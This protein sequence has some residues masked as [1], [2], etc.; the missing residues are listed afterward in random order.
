M[1]RA[2]FGD[3]FCFL[4]LFWFSLQAAFSPHIMNISAL[5][6]LAWKG[7]RMSGNLI[8]TAEMY[9]KTVY[10]LEEDGI[11]ALRARIVDRLG[12][13]GPTVSE[14]VAR[15]ERD[16]L[17]HVGAGRKIY[18]TDK[19]FD[20]AEGVMRRHRLAECLLH[21]VIGLDWASVHD[22]A[23]RWEHVVSD[24]V[25]DRIEVLLNFPERDP[26]GNPI[27]AKRDPEGCATALNVRDVA[28]AGLR[29]LGDIARSYPDTNGEN[30]FEIA[31]FS[32]R[33]QC[34][35]SDLQ[36]FE[37]AGLLI[38]ANVNVI[39]CGDQE[40]CVSVAGAELYIPLVVA[41]GIY[42]R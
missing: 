10:E 15:L 30:T 39:D 22:E 4:A 14:T 36:Q 17:L 8:D 19:G 7:N 12:Q 31:R 35:P 38:G 33:V 26:F 13:S 18:F 20:R 28:V 24:D 40:V 25:A 21:N 1:Y 29:S 5:C 9:L 41:D 6:D 3:S 2:E 42:V 32:E 23:C 27:P 34:E 16:G 11:P 37:S